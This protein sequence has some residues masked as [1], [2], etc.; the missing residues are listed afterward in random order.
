MA[1]KAILQLQKSIKDLQIYLMKYV[2]S[3]VPS[4]TPQTRTTTI[5]TIG[6][7]TS[8]TTLPLLHSED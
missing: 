2:G 8:H 6:N 1:E 7:M 4:P 5:T 3:W